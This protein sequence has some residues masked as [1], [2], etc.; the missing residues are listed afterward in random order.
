MIRE[1]LYTMGYPKIT[2]SLMLN[3]PGTNAILATPLV[4]LLRPTKKVAIRRQMVDPEP[5]IIPNPGT[6]ATLI[7]LGI[8]S[9]AA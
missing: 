1:I 9:P 5:P 4:A 8:A 3:N 7:M 2:G 6:K